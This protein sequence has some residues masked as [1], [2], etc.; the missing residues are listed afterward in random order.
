MADEPC[1]LHEESVKEASPL[2]RDSNAE[3]Q[4]SGDPSVV[5]QLRRVLQRDYRDF[6]AACRK[7]VLEQKREHKQEAKA[8]ERLQLLEQLRD[9]LSESCQKTRQRRSSAMRLS[10]LQEEV[11]VEVRKAQLRAK[12][13][14]EK[15][16]PLF[17]QGIPYLRSRLFAAQV[18]RRTGLENKRLLSSCT[19]TWSCHGANASC[20]AIVG[21]DLLEG[22]AERA[23]GA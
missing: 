10:R 22:G 11:R 15:G 20:S 7:T 18:R 19:A 23:G 2:G 14:S 12:D 13:P 17:A 9:V 1:D 5:D 16:A 3:A 8:L 4:L 21:L 6:A